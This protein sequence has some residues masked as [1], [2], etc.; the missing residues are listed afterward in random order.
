MK[1]ATK[2]LS[3]DEEGYVIFGEARVTD[4]SVGH[5]L[6]KNIH[7]SKSGAYFTVLNDERILVEAFDEPYIAQFILTQQNHIGW[8][9]MLPYG[10]E[11][12]FNPSTLTVDEWDRFHGHT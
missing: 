6:L 1:G 9:I 5:S 11:V 4:P 3:I 10:L 8:K 2:H 7:V 12:K